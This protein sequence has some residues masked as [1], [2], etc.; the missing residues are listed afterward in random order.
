LWN[1]MAGI[2]KQHDR[3]ELTMLHW[4]RLPRN[5]EDHACTATARAATGQPVRS[6]RDTCSQGVRVPLPISQRC[7]SW[8][9]AVVSACANWSWDSQRQRGPQQPRVQ[10]A[11]MA[12]R[13]I[14]RSPALDSA[15]APLP[16]SPR[17]RAP[18]RPAL[19]HT[20]EV[21]Q[22]LQL[23]QRSGLRQAADLARRVQP[24]PAARY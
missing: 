12:P 6:A 2:V 1:R 24:P 14:G 13:L 10:A 7:A 22:Q 18:L 20:A 15:S 4:N 5:D 17:V 8:R 16:P 11:A 19:P 9:S 23:Q 3:F 21:P